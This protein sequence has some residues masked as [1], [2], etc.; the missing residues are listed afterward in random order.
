MRFLDKPVDQLGKEDLDDLRGVEKPEGLYLKFKGDLNNRQVARSVAAFANTHGGRLLIGV[1]ADKKRNLITAIPGIA[2]E[3]GLQER[4]KNVVR[5]TVTPAP[6]FHPHLV[7][8][9]PG[10]V[11]IVVDVP[12]S[13]SPPHLL[14]SS[15]QVYVRTPVSSDPVPADD[16]V[17]ID[18]MYVR[19]A[20]GRNRIDAWTEDQFSRFQPLLRERH[21]LICQR[22]IPVWS[23]GELLPDLFRRTAAL[24]FEQLLANSGVYGAGG[25]FAPDQTGIVCGY[26]DP[27]T[28]DGIRLRL[29]RNG[30]LTHAAFESQRE[31]GNSVDT[32]GDFQ[33]PLFIAAEHVVTGLHHLL[34]LQADVCARV[35]FY[36]SM[37]LVITVT[38][39]DQIGL[40]YHDP[41]GWRMVTAP[42]PYRRL[43]LDRTL[44]LAQLSE[45]PGSVVAGVVREV[46]RAFGVRAY[47]PDAEG[48]EA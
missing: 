13:P 30:G 7:E 4:V 39:T 3:D 18:R 31:P 29:D 45:D 16:R 43:D 33:P 41:S 46:Q 32:H 48:T 12:E 35:G 22:I 38:P 19:A 25:D 14:R 27:R 10:L 1:E 26:I 42:L 21:V 36:G 15:G 6:L 20:A 28:G 8:L 47:E 17:T 37:R 9:G 44:A 2:L 34:R 23:G 24:E 5:D 11:V 40:Q